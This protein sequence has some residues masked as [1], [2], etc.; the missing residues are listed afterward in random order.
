MAT[1]N[2]DKVIGKQCGDEDINGF[3]DADADK[4]DADADKDDGGGGGADGARCQG[5][6]LEC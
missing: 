2:T 4:D 6:S 5:R 3:D 1:A